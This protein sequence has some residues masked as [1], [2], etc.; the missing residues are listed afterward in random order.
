MQRPLSD[1]TQ[2]SKETDIHA[3]GGIRTQNPR[4]QVVANHTLHHADTVISICLIIIKKK[5][6]KQ[7][8]YRPGVA[9]RVPGS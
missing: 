7:S 6:V 4:K 8:H 5:K 2:H 1:N 3:S 9:Q